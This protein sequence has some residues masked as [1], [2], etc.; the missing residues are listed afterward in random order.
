MILSKV[1]V[2]LVEFT[3]CHNAQNPNSKHI[4]LI[5]SLKP[6]WLLKDSS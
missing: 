4:L 2:S 1:T 5:M 6:V 3:E